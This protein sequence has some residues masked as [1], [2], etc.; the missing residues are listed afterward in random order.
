M[1]LESNHWSSVDLLKE[2]EFVYFQEN[3]TITEDETVYTSGDGGYFNSGI[4]VGMTKIQDDKTYVIP[5][6]N[7]EEL[8]YLQIFL[9]NFKS[10]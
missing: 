5:T 1:C 9:N 6:N 10:F 2:L 3:Q 4:P 8:Q 7:L